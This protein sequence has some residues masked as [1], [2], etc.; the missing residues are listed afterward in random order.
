M[1]LRSGSGST[2]FAAPATAGPA[3]AAGPMHAVWIIGLEGALSKGDPTKHMDPNGPQL[4]RNR[5][6]FCPI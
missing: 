4:P 1:H 3:S 5:P 6:H 2:R